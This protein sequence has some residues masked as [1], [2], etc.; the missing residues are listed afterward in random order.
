M[1]NARILAV[2]A[3]VAVLLY[4]S[5]SS[6]APV[7]VGIVPTGRAGWNSPV[8]APPPGPSTRDTVQGIAGGVAGG[9]GAAFG[10]PQLGAVAAPVAGW[11][12]DARKTLDD[13]FP[14]NW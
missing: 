4:R 14:W 6:A 10:V 1:S 8:G 3:L 2:G 5:R 13:V 7:A 11:I 9:V 12:Y